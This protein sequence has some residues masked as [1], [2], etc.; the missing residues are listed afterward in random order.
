MNPMNA[1]RKLSQAY[2]EWRRLAEAEGAAMQ[3]DDWALVAT[4]QK[5]L[6]RLQ[7]RITRL[8]PA[9]RREWAQSADD[10]TAREGEL[11]ATIHDLIRLERQNLTLVA[12]KKEVVR[13][14]LDRLRQTGRTLK[15]IQRSYLSNRP[16]TWTSFS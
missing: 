1:G 12:A 10:R 5:G 16:A 6:R 13:M 7:A 3:A 11:N 8:G 9:A 4:C 15:Q 2:A 14:Q